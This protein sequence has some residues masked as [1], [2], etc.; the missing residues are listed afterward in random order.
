MIEAPL[1]CRPVYREGE[2]RA[3][4]LREWTQ[5]FATAVE[6]FAVA[7]PYQVFLFQD[8]W[9]PASTLDDHGTP[10]SRAGRSRRIEMDHEGL[11]G[12]NAS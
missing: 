9:T 1:V 10:S 4:Q 7:H 8:V 12:G 3:R 2:D 5:A 6:G 11:A